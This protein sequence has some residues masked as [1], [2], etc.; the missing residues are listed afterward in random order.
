M[1]TKTLAT[2][3]KANTR[4]ARWKKRF[5]DALRESPHIGLACAAAGIGRTAAYEARKNDPAFSA[6][7]QET[8]DASLDDIEV[9]A[10]HLALQGNVPLIQFLL[11]A[12]RRNVYGDRTEHQHLLAGKVVFML[13]EKEEREP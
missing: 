5:L 11:K 3:N 8:L 10:V 1:E 9:K 6:Q 7:W 13:P 2:T 4:T 12:H